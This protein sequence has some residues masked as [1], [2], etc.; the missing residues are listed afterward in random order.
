MTGMTLWQ[1]IAAAL[2]VGLALAA[3][4]WAQ[5][6]FILTA[7]ESEV[8]GIAQR[9][10]LVVLDR[11]AERDVFLVRGP[12][13]VQPGTVI[14]RV[15]ADPELDDE[16]DKVFME[17]DAIV[18][19]PEAGLARPLHSSTVDAVQALRN[20]RLVTFHGSRVW[21]NYARQ[22]ATT[23]VRVADAHAAYGLGAGII[24]VI[25][26]GVD[27]TH[28]ALA[29]ALVG[30]FDFTRDLPDIS[31]LTDI[32]AA[33]PILNPDNVVILDNT[34][35]VA[36]NP[37]TQVLVEAGQAAAL[38]PGAL[39]ETFGHGTM[40]ASVVRLVA[41]GAQIMPLKTFGADGR[42]RLWNVVRALYHAQEAGANV[43]NLSLGSPTVS[44]ALGDAVYYLHE[45]QMFCVASV[46]NEGRNTLRY[47]AAFPEALGVASVRPTDRRSAFSNYGAALVKV[48]APGEGLV[49]AYPAGQYALAWGT[50]FSAPLASGAI[51]LMLE[52]KSGINWD[53]VLRAFAQ[54]APVVDTGMGAGRLD[55]MR[56][57]GDA[58]GFVP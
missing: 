48:S 6:R 16:D 54:A 38:A 53:E 40:V 52:V 22:R 25:D 47:P 36:I 49:V 15:L 24:A 2:T 10:G 11:V 21:A 18:R 19:L 23:K 8:P 33:H 3:P 55:V 28:P 50:S 29:G 9:N 20:T 35:V 42:G 51:A 57:V 27:P 34:S 17:L 39:P 45:K 41:P 14:A 32:D 7:P 13:G 43:V 26:A 46:G 4:A 56:A 44:K 12:K 58:A 1:R 30:G 5:D 31:E 37:S